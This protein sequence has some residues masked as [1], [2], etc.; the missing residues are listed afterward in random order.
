MDKRSELSVTL[1]T[2]VPVHEAMV[3]A[4][5]IG[6]E[7]A[8]RIGGASPSRLAGINLQSKELRARFHIQLVDVL[9]GFVH[10][11]GNAFCFLE[12]KKAD[13]AKSACYALTAQKVFL[14]E[15]SNALL[16]P[17]RMWPISEPEVFLTHVY[18]WYRE[19][20]SVA[21]LCFREQGWEF[22]AD[23]AGELVIRLT[24]EQEEAPPRPKRER[25]KPLIFK[26]AHREPKK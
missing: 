8:A 13:A 23:E 12:R 15:V 14:P 10:S 24:L 16:S 2:L 4:Q 18:D 21:P 19:G 1:C 20:V 22:I 17:H 7:K 3:D 25:A 6:M 5:I 9:L 26:F 11:V